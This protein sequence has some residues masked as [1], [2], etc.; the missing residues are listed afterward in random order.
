[1]ISQALFVVPLNTILLYILE[2]L[3]RLCRLP[4]RGALSLPVCLVLGRVRFS[5][6]CRG[7][8]KGGLLSV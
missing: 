6:A 8:E 2:P 4:P 1:M 5:A 7:K 3:L